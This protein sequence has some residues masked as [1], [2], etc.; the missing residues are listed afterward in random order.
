MAAGLPIVNTHLATTVPLVARQDREALTV[1]PNDPHALSQAL[2]SI[3]DE[4]A[5]AQRLGEAGRQ[6]AKNEFDQAVFRTRMA[7]I[8]EEAVRTRRNRVAAPR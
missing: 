3:L 6:R 1:P 8:Y 7:A 5:L 2:N 4:P